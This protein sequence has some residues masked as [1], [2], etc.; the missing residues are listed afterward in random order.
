MITF[1]YFNILGMTGR[2]WREK[3][4]ESEIKALTDEYPVSL[5][6]ESRAAFCVGVSFTV[7]ESVFDSS[8]GAVWYIFIFFTVEWLISNKGN[9][10]ISPPQFYKAVHGDN[11]GKRI[12]SLPPVSRLP[13]QAFLLH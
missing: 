3:S 2:N 7:L 4:M 9:L 13:P 11:L 10:F 6:M 12:S 5:T 8:A 1:S